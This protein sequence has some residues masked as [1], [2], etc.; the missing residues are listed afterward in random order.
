MVYSLS[1]CLGVAMPVKK[2]RV[3]LEGIL[4]ENLIDKTF[5]E[6]LRKNVDSELRPVGIVLVDKS[7]VPLVVTHETPRDIESRIVHIQSPNELLID[8]IVKVFE[9]AKPK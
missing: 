2:E 9:E 6:S 3:S 4:V 8:R 7:G 5:M 1:D